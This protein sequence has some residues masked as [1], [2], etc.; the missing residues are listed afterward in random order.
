MSRHRLEV[1]IEAQT[2][3]FES[4]MQRATQS[5]ERLN[6]KFNLAAI[7]VAGKMMVDG[8]MRIGRAFV[9]MM[10]EAFKAI[11]A[12]EK[13]SRQV[14]MSSNVIRSWQLAASEAGVEQST[15]ERGLQRLTRVLGDAQEGN[16]GAIS[17]L[18]RLGITQEELADMDTDQAFRRISDAI[19]GAETA[20]ERAS[21]ANEVFGRSGLGLVNMLSEGSEALETYE[22]RARE[23]GLHLSEEGVAGV[24]AFNDSWGELGL[25]WEGIQQQIAAELGPLLLTLVEQFKEW[26]PSMEVIGEWATWFVD[27]IADLIDLGHIMFDLWLAQLDAMISVLARVAQGITRVAGIFSRNMRDA[28]DQLGQWAD[29]AGER[30]ASRVKGAW[31]RFVYG[32]TDR[33]L[34]NTRAELRNLGEEA[35]RQ[36]YSLEELESALDGL[37]DTCDSIAE[38]MQKVENSISDLTE[39][40][41]TF[42]MT[43]EELA[44]DKMI[45]LGATDEDLRHFQRLQ[46]VLADLNE[47]RDQQNR[48]ESDA[49]KVIESLRT[50]QQLLQ[51]QL[52][53]LRKMYEENLLTLEEYTE[54]RKRALEEAQ[55]EDRPM[56]EV[57]SARAQ[58]YMFEARQDARGLNE[59]QIHIAEHQRTL[60]QQIARNTRQSPALLAIG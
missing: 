5:T 55:E 34:D 1:A 20:T 18:E 52:A 56:L 40:I 43:A 11:D 48:L 3:R 53:G 57:G 31:D 22:D 39:E 32:G 8:I 7:A 36:T 30:A 10:A 21:L 15:L 17:S 12:V 44:L 13:F 42:G 54:A 28:S 47:Q 6:K 51:E 25:I 29:E 38:N 49:K 46:A 16:E 26:I 60:L 2:A 33:A 45:S 35:D 58:R 59:R 19:A 24:E 37:E 50:P 41:R 14:G 9:S 27:R 4:A 23:L